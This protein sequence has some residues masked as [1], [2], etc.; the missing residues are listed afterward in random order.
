MT[1]LS[2][3]AVV[4]DILDN[5]HSTYFREPSIKKEIHKHIDDY[6]S[7]EPLLMF[8]HVADGSVPS[9][10]C[11][12]I[13]LG[14]M[15]PSYT[16]RGSLVESATDA[17]I[18]SATSLADGYPTSYQATPR[19]FQMF[20]APLPGP[21]E[22]SY[23]S[24]PLAHSHVIQDPFH[25]R[26][27]AV[28]SRITPLDSANIVTHPRDYPVIP[29]SYQ[30]SSPFGDFSRNVAV[31]L[32]P[33]PPPKTSTVNEIPRGVGWEHSSSAPPLETST[34]IP[35]RS[36]RVDPVFMVW[37]QA[38]L[39]KGEYSATHPHLS[40]SGDSELPCMWDSPLPPRRPIHPRESVS[41]ET[42]SF[43]F[44]AAYRCVKSDCT[45]NGSDS[46]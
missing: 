23:R 42:P 46:F 25:N 9:R 33:S 34:P 17:S 1:F 38:Q 39:A 5:L 18:G 45:F 15:Y 28:Q 27:D 35:R 26:V 8:A 7:N 10:P 43:C 22:A 6:P 13:D 37:L 16:N 29:P 11:N 41:G 12:D 4:P 44:P 32:P 21:S 14:Y 30:V 36:E 31:V 24:N 20:Q 3:S 2:H 40:P 19:M